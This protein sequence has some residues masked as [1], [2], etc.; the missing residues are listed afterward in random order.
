MKKMKSLKNKILIATGGTGGHVFPAYGVANHFIKNS[1]N[2]KHLNFDAVFEIF[3]IIII[4]YLKK[5]KDLKTQESKMKS[6]K[7]IDQ[8]IKDLDK[9]FREQGIGDMSIGKYVKKYVKKFYF[10]LKILDEILKQNIDFNFNDYLV[11]FGI[12]NYGD[13]DKITED[14]NI[15]FN[16]ILIDK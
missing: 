15:L 7:I 9:N 3:C 4:F 12:S 14:M 8:F 16:E 1:L 11:R 10:R 13:S 6:Q 5:L 2:D